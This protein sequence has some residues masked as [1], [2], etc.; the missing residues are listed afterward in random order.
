MQDTNFESHVVRG[1]HGAHEA[2]DINTLSVSK[3]GLVIAAVTLVSMMAMWFLLDLM[4]SFESKSSP[5]PH[6]MVAQ[7]PMKEPPLPHLQGHPRPDLAAFQTEEARKL[8]EYKWVDGEKKLVQIPVERALDIV[9]RDGKLPV[10]IPAAPAK[11][12]GGAPK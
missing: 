8:A 9:A 7:D 3:F 2:T 10:W 6:P 4:V 1:P 11:A 12:P 5:K